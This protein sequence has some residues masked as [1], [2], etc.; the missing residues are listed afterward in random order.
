MLI[1]CCKFFAEFSCNSLLIFTNFA[2]PSLFDLCPDFFVYYIVFKECLQCIYHYILLV[3][4]SL[5]IMLINDSFRYFC[6][7]V[8][9]FVA[10]ASSYAFIPPRAFNRCS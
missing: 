4:W 6:A 8:S 10:C 3:Y 1:L 9:S 7:L 5:L 2:F